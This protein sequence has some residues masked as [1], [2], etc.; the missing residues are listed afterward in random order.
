MVEFSFAVKSINQEFLGISMQIFFVVEYLIFRFFFSCIPC[1][2]LKA[3]N[4]WGVE[5]HFTTGKKTLDFSLPEWQATIII[6]F[7]NKNGISKS[8]IEANVSSHSEKGFGEAVLNFACCFV[9]STVTRFHICR[10]VS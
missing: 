8:S 2:Y 7:I 4:L 5:I 6:R 3:E 1:Y 10:T 9:I